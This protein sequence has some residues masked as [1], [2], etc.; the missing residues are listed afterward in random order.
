MQ[1]KRVQNKRVQNKKK[2]AV[3]AL[4][5]FSFF[6]DPIA[7]QP[8]MQHLFSKIS[9]IHVYKMPRRYSSRHPGA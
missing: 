8:K 3:T 5:T 9:S 4:G 1:N 7:S 2:I 6:P